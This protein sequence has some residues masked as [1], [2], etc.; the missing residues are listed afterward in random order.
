ME[1]VQRRATQV[2]RVLEYLSCEELGLFNLE[3]TGKDRISA[4]KYL[5]GEF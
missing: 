2:I 1:R 4:H 3:K 5:K